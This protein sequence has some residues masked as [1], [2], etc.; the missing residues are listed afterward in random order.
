MQQSWTKINKYRWKQIFLIWRHTLVRNNL[1]KKKFLAR[2]TRIHPPFSLVFS[3]AWVNFLRIL[4]L[5]VSSGNV[6]MSEMKN[7]RK[8]VIACGEILVLFPSK[9][10]SVGL[11]LVFACNINLW[12]LGP[13]ILEFSISLDNVSAKIHYYF[14]SDLFFH[15]SLKL[16]TYSRRVRKKSTLNLRCYLLY[17]ELN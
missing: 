9:I 1:Q 5:I 3:F 15:F 6:R 17:K 12:S 2:K 7:K 16:C 4:E 11:L 10:N 14:P 8:I 13:S